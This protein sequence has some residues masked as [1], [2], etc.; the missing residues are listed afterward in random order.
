MQ[1]YSPQY[2]WQSLEPLIEVSGA[3]ALDWH[4]GKSPHVYWA[5]AGWREENKARIANITAPVEEVVDPILYAL[6]RKAHT[7]Q[8]VIPVF[9]S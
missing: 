6:G 1:L 2:F 3:I 9:P 8:D 4:Y 7:W 5:T